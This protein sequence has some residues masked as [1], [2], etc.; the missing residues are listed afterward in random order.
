MKKPSPASCARL[1]IGAALVAAAAAAAGAETNLADAPIIVSTEVP[2]NVM[3]ALSVEWPTGTVAAYN[4][5]TSSA[6]GYGCSGRDGGVGVCYFPERTYLGYFDPAKCYSYNAGDGYFEPKSVLT[7]AADGTLSVNCAAQAGRWS[8]NFL[9]WSAM[10]ALDSFRYAMTGGD[11]VVDT[12]TLTVVE[13]SQHTGQGGYGQFPRKRIGT[14][15]SAND[16][17][18]PA[19]PPSTQTPETWDNLFTRVTDSSRPLGE[20]FPYAGKVVQVANNVNF[21][22]AIPNSRYIK[23]QLAGTNSLSL[24]EVVVRNSANTDL[25]A[26]RPTSQSS[27]NYG[28]VDSRAVDGNRDGVFANNSVTHTN[29][30]YRPWW[31]VDLGASSQISRIRIFNRT[32]CCEDRLTNFYIFAASFDM[33]GYTVEQLLAN[34]S[35]WKYRR[36]DQITDSSDG[37]TDDDR[38]LLI[39]PQTT[40]VVRDPMYV[41][42]KVCDSTIGLES[43]CKSYGTVYKPTGVVQDKAAKMRFGVTSYLNVDSK[44]S[45]GGVLRSPLKYVGPQTIVPNGTPG[46]N[47]RYEIDSNGLVRN[48][49]DGVV[50]AGGEYKSSGVINYINR[51]GKTGTKS[52]LKSYDT[53]SEMYYETLRYLRGSAASGSPDFLAAT[54]EFVTYAGADSAAARDGFPIYTDWTLPAWTDVSAIDKEPVQYWCQK[55]S[56][57]GIG[58]TNAWCD[59]WGPGTGLDSNCAE[60]K[61][62]GGPSNDTRINAKNLADTI[63]SGEAGLTAL[64]NTW[65]SESR[66]N[67]YYIASYAYWANSKDIIE[68]DAARG[69]KKNDTDQT[70][71]TYWVDV[72]ETGSFN[73]IVPNKNQYWLAGRWGGYDNGSVASKGKITKTEPDDS[74]LNPENSTYFTGERPDKLISALKSVF[75]NIDGAPGTAAPTEL[76]SNNL[77]NSSE[78]YQVSFD[79]STWTGEVIGSTVKFN[80]DGDIEATEVWRAAAQLDATNWDT[81]RKIVSYDPVAKTGVA[82]RASGSSKL[83][84]AQLAYFG[85]IVAQRPDLIN[86]LRGDRTYETGAAARYRQRVSVL[87]DIVNAEPRVVGAPPEGFDEEMNPGFAKFYVDQKDRKKVLYVAANDGML[88]A[89]DGTP[90]ASGGKELFAFIPSAVLSGPSNP[91][92]PSVDG[93]AHRASLGLDHRFLVD[94]APTVRSV[95]FGN[96]G[97]GTPGTPAWRTILVGGLGKGGRSFYALDVTNPDSWIDEGDV[98]KNVLWEFTDADMGYSFAQPVITKMKAYGWVVILTSG[99]NNTTSSVTADRGK[100]FIYI[101]NAKTGALLRKKSTGEGSSSAPSGLAKINAFTPDSGDF[102][103]DAAYAGDLLGNLWRFDLTADDGAV[104]EPQRIAQFKDSS[105]KAQAITAEP[106]VLV[107]PGTVDRWVFVGTGRL[108]DPSDRKNSQD[109]AFYAFRD[110]TRLSFATDETLPDDI[111]FPIT[112]SDLAEVD[113]AALETGLTAEQL[114]GKI[115]WVRKFTKEVD[116]ANERMVDFIVGNSGVVAFATKIPATR[117]ECSPD[118]E[119]RVYAVAY[120]D[121]A[122][123]LVDTAGDVQKWF[124][125]KEG[126]LR[127]DLLIDGSG[128]LKVGFNTGTGIGDIRDTKERSGGPVRLNWR[129]VIQ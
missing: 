25:A 129:E 2:P 123:Q 76:T 34:T 81:E 95:D 65:I 33:S 19:T 117:D 41:R 89:F 15:Y 80:D 72:R 8:G 110:G 20:F 39:N 116:G 62:D 108:L 43:N 120:A 127:A 74:F 105:S 122:S 68:D 111:S 10:H 3:M 98:A 46:T 119:S 84:D 53:V 14:A 52:T 86:Y 121:A 78:S 9:N 73:G 107:N 97:G 36:V 67:S 82:F 77:A 32:D 38:E 102:T 22:N 18:V 87:G 16:V 126:V 64:G 103:A 61:H 114:A 94:Q 93:I 44:E 71:Q 1:F 112:S 27:T 35:V 79:S 23:I 56:I 12:T 21:W 90:D 55:T 37:T 58:D 4:D 101:L 115:G 60:S 125:S 91:A 17:D 57:V 124:E 85:D 106:R 96:T 31:Q 70:V 88:H 40:D 7:K 28:G 100:G 26:G 66:A 63:G 48:D 99:Y 113:N 45:M 59:S 29:S 11:R 47:P 54:P 75:N 30:E 50:S 83:S 49:P 118:V 69:Y 13:K 24:A 92:T 109:Q 104:P 51:F 5:N 128:N 42:A 6:T